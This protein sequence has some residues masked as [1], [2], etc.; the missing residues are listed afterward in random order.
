MCNDHNFC[1]TFGLDP[2]VNGPL[3]WGS[4]SFVCDGGGQSPVNIQS[5]DAT[6]QEYDTALTL[7][8]SSDDSC[9]FGNGEICGTLI[10]NGRALVF[11][12]NM[13]IDV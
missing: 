7:E 4:V 11:Q 2:V 13:K 1:L 6:K 10:N 5:N 9:N 12:V 3:E 8:F